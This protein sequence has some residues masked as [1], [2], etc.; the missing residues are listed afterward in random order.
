MS[1][2][3]RAFKSFDWLDTLRNR[4]KVHKHIAT[5]G[6][7]Y[8]TCTIKVEIPILCNT[9]TSGYPQ[10]V[11]CRMCICRSLLGFVVLL[12][13]RLLGCLSV[14]W[15]TALLPKAFRNLVSIPF[16][17]RTLLLCLL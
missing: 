13:L 16:A 4:S 17:V 3:N 9:I 8:T 2:Q 1:I 6:N 5:T 15:F 14:G 7:M 11:G 10:L 12:T